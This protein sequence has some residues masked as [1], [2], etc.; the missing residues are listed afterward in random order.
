MARR[1]A[2]RP[3]LFAAPR[4]PTTTARGRCPV[5]P[6]RPARTPTL[7]LCPLIRMKEKRPWSNHT[8]ERGH[9]APRAKRRPDPTRFRTGS[10]CFRC[11][12]P[13]PGQRATD[14]GAGRAALAAS[15]PAARTA[16]VPGTGGP[17]HRREGCEAWDGKAVSGAGS[18]RVG[19]GRSEGAA[20]GMHWLHKHE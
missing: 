6:W 2:A 11:G 19:S 5:V 15:S 16:S 9:A 7:G 8:H 3:S 1:L 13:S 18:V 14:E 4:R 17:R 20:R 10:L 12:P